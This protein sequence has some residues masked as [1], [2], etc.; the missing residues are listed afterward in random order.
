MRISSLPLLAC[1]QSVRGRRCGG[2]L[3]VLESLP[4]ETARDDQGE[5]LEAVLACTACRTE[6]PIVCGVLLLLD[7]LD[8]YLLIRGAGILEATADLPVSESIRQ[9]L[10]GSAP[11]QRRPPAPA[12]NR[13]DHQR[14]SIESY[15]CAHYDRLP[16]LERT[17][18]P[19]Q[20]LLDMQRAGDMWAAIDRHL[21]PLRFEAALDVGCNVG[22]MVRRLARRSERVLGIDMAFPTV[23]IARRIL[24][25]QPTPLTTYTNSIECLVGEPV[26]IAQEPVGG[27]VD[28]LVASG[29]EAPLRG[30]FDVVSALN[31]ID[32]VTEPLA[33]LRQ[34]AKWV[35][36]GGR[37]LLTSPYCWSMGPATPEKWLGGRDGQRSADVIR[38]LVREQGLTIEWDEDDLPWIM[39]TFSRWFHVNLVHALLARRP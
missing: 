22:G 8:E 18:H 19:L 4:C 11:G 23:L 15:V 31:V 30:D 13:A 1:P 28:V 34:M 32:V 16:D 36:P 12:D 7:N 17:P 39:R 38:R 5:L 2:P 24:L 14:L 37:L 35:R 21:E 3:S 25:H 33:L 20:A 9:R 6:Y 26:E 29:L 27:D 10:R